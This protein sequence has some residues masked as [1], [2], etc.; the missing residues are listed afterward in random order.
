M[1]LCLIIVYFILYIQNVLEYTVVVLSGLGEDNP[2]LVQLANSRAVR[3]DG[4]GKQPITALHQ[5]EEA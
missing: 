4:Q 5:T 2:E 3:R 1:Y